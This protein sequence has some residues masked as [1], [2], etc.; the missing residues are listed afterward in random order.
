MQNILIKEI[1]FTLILGFEKLIDKR[2][3][4]TTIS[5]TSLS[6]KIGSVIGIISSLSSGNNKVIIKEEEFDI[7]EFNNAKD[8]FEYMES[9]NDTYT[10][11]DKVIY[12]S[13]YE[14]IEELGIEEF[15][16]LKKLDINQ[17]IIV[18][19]ANSVKNLFL[20]RYFGYILDRVKSEVEAINICKEIAHYLYNEITINLTVEKSSEISKPNEFEQYA[21]SQI[22]AALKILEGEI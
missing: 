16:A 4:T 14:T 5:L 3:F 6:T 8:F 9:N 12:N 7:L 11:D 1:K 2:E 22:L 17:F 10:I 19:V 13:L 15:D 20:Q 21:N 18:F